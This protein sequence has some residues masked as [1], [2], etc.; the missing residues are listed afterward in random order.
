[1]N[2]I[3]DAL[4]DNEDGQ[5]S[6]TEFTSGSA[7]FLLSSKNLK[8]AFDALDSNQDGQINREELEAAFLNRGGI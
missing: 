7:Y 6:Y 3:F 8:Q 4:D 5:I 1:M 2:E